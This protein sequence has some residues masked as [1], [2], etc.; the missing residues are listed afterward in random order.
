MRRDRHYFIKETSDQ[1][2]AVASTRHNR[3]NSNANFHT[4]KMKRKEHNKKTV[5]WGLRKTA[6]VERANTEHAAIHTMALVAHHLDDGANAKIHRDGDQTP[7]SMNT[8][9]FIV[10]RDRVAATAATAAANGIRIVLHST[11][12]TPRICIAM[13]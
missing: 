8:R 12:Y 5:L 13:A 4:T 3:T 2:V 7:A 9:T 10:V 1:T 11:I 6:N